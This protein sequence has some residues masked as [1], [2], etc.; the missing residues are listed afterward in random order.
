MCD[1]GVLAWCCVVGLGWACH[2]KRAGSGR[3]VASKIG[4]IGLQMHPG[5][6]GFE[7]VAKGDKGVPKFGNP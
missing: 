6:P 1:F 2:S 7:A 3:S 5:V 4:R